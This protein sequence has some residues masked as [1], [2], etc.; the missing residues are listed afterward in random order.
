MKNLIFKYR[1]HI[2]N[3]SLLI[4]VMTLLNVF[5]YKNYIRLG[6]SFKYLFEALIFYF[7]RIFLMDVTPPYSPFNFVIDNLNTF[8]YSMIIP[9]DY[10]Y[11]IDYLNSGFFMIYNLDYFL[12]STQIFAFIFLYLNIIIS[13][14]LCVIIITLIISSLYQKEKDPLII[15]ERRSSIIYKNFKDKYL[16]K[17]IIELK[18][19][20]EF[21]K[22]N[23]YYLS[24]LI[25]NIA[26]FT[27]V[28]SLSI[29]FIG[30]LFIM[31][32]NILLLPIELYE[33]FFVILATLYPVFNTLPLFIWIILAL[34]IFILIRNKRAKQ[35]IYSLQSANERFCEEHLGVATLTTG[36]M[37]SGKDSFN[38]EVV[39]TM[40]RVFKRRLKEILL[41]YKNLFNDFDFISYEKYLTLA[42]TERYFDISLQIKTMIL[43]LKEYINNGNEVAFDEE[44]EKYHF[45]KEFFN[46]QKIIFNGSQPLDVFDLLLNYGQAY[47]LYCDIRP[48]VYSNIGLRLSY[49]VQNQDYFPLFDFDIF[50]EKDEESFILRSHKSRNW[51]MDTWRLGIRFDKNT[52][53]SDCGIYDLSEGGKERGNLYTNAGKDKESNTPNQKNDDFNKYVKLLRHVYT[54][55]YYPFIK[56]LV[57]D[58]RINSI[59]ADLHELFE[60]VVSLK[61]V[62][63][64]KNSLWLYA[65]IEKPFLEVLIGSFN[66]MLETYRETRNYTSL[67]Y[68][69]ISKINYYLTIHK[70]KIEGFYNYKKMEMN[71][72]MAGIEDLGNKEFYLI[73]KEAYAGNFATDCYFRFFTPLIE[74]RKDRIFDI[75]DYQNIYASVNEFNK[76]HSLLVTDIQACPAFNPP[77]SKEEFHK[78]YYEIIKNAC[79]S[80]PKQNLKQ[81]FKILE[82]NYGSQIGKYKHFC[83][84]VKENEL[85][86][87]KKR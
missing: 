37:E 50:E 76:Q 26:I 7:Q 31:I 75:G 81:I 69:F 78:K 34:I 61:K 86:D 12:E 48:N 16:N 42:K 10:N 6:F 8:D 9:K 21:N 36:V 57:N 74:K 80:Y 85:I 11:F 77:L 70:S 5:L 15:G 67:F 65:T 47:F 66:R 52:G 84:Y 49:S 43:N 30:Y 53:L 25:L 54:I 32:G 27:N 1:F 24:I 46:Y 79:K 55:N 45:P 23:R 73:Y 41:L 22:L 38:V 35:K 29:E 14:I 59:N 3:I 72:Q 56:L 39:M 64:I 63:K 33:M 28:L 83:S 13:L 71:I 51:D 19:Y 87:R 60:T 2:I 20:H 40:Q 18:N 17:I 4:I 58:Q 44:L 82:K 62:K 68:M